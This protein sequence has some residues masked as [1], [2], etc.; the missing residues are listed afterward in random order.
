VLIQIHLLQNYAPANLNRDDTGAPKDTLFGGI[1][2]GRIS[3]QCLK[4]SIRKSAAFAEAFESDGLLAVRTKQLPRLVKDAL[5][6]LGVDAQS[7][8]AIVARVPEI[9]RESARR[10]AE[11][12]EGEEETQATETEA[13]AEDE[14]KQLIFLGHDEVRPLAEKL[15]AL[16]QQYG[17][18][19][20][21]A[22]AKI[23][24]I[25]KALGKSVPRSVDVAMFGRM[26]TSEAF[27]DVQAAVQVAHAISTN[28]L[29]E[30]FDYYTAVDD[31]SGKTGAGMIGDV[32]Y[33]CSTYY[34]YLNVHWEQLVKN[35]GGDVAVARR[36]ILALVEAAATAQ[37]TG[38]QNTFA[39][40]CLPDLV[41][42]E[43]REKNLPVNYANAFLKPAH[44][45]GD[46]TVV[47]DSVAKL[48]DYI[49]R[50]GRAYGLTA[51][52]RALTAMQDYA[53]PGAENRASLEELQA[54]LAQHLPE[55]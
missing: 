52:K 20:K 9:G 46:Q 44:W 39:A 7:I 6:D 3:S 31:L 10:A 35:L 1:R 33:N 54:W 16:Y 42:I 43:A 38:K 49:A 36:A 27:E 29:A 15:L 17:D 32:E 11:E 8:Q 53:L 21:W 28:A 2:R 55:E 45:S 48:A 4:R 25:T 50:V 22:K 14:T 40:H 26:T 37:P 51:D 24:D 34:K 47:D 18:S 12:E 5:N 19:K 30:E 41:L 23:A 13:T